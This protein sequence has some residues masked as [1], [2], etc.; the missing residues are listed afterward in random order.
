MVHLPEGALFVSPEYDLLG[1]GGLSAG[2]P[3]ATLS[4]SLQPRLHKGS[5]VQV[6]GSNQTGRN[7]VTCQRAQCCMA[8]LDRRGQASVPL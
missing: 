8:P 6:R 4:G 5:K 7:V 2:S 1:A 3:G